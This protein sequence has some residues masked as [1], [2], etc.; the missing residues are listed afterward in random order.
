MMS[1]DD[2]S[3]KE[4]EEAGKHK[5]EDELFEGAEEEEGEERVER[6]PA[7]HRDVIDT[8]EFGDLDEEEES[9]TF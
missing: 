3:D 1:D 6:T 2:A 4:E 5:I 8:N 7:P 9:G